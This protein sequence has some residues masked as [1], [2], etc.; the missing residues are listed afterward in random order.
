MIATVVIGGFALC[1]I[2]IVLRWQVPVW[3]YPVAAIVG[4]LLLLVSYRPGRRP[5]SVDLYASDAYSDAYLGRAE[6]T[7][8]HHETGSESQVGPGPPLDPLRLP[9]NEEGKPRGDLP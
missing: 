7:H 1:L 5:S 2:S 9:P 3:L 6:P 4:L 8:P